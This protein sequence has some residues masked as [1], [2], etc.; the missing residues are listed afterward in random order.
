MLVF[1]SL[2]T[3]FISLSLCDT[4]VRHL[5]KLGVDKYASSSKQS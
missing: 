4:S 2:D 1:S 5:M 3:P